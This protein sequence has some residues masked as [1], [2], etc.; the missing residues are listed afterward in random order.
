MYFAING[1]NW[2]GGC[3]YETTEAAEAFLER[4]KTLRCDSSKLADCEVIE[5]MDPACVFELWQMKDEDWAHGHKFF[6]YKMANSEGNVAKPFYDCVYRAVCTKAPGPQVLGELFQRFN[7]ERPDDF[8][9]A[10]MSVSDVIVFKKGEVR[11]AF[12][13]EPIG[14]LEVPF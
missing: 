1:T 13:V 12:F 3:L 8:M 9:A 7:C 6:A 11:R 14:F 5:V 2:R 4:L 10:S